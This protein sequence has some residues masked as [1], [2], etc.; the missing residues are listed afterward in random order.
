M[1]EPT[2]LAMP[3]AT[4]PTP[5]PPPPPPPAPKKKNTTRNIL[6]GCGIALVLFICCVA[7][8]VVVYIERDNIPGLDKLFAS[9][10]GGTQN[11]DLIAFT[12]YRNGGEGDI[13]VIHADG[14]GE[15]QITDDPA[16]D[17]D[18]EWSPDGKKL[19]FASNRDGDNEIYI[20]NADGPAPR[21]S[22]SNPATMPPRP[23]RPMAP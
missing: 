23:S 1:D 19:A 14:T 9:S 15:V 18:A 16:N 22:L 10:A 5:V 20:M 8:V 12:S 4:P 13:F 21:A 7:V 17:T 11:G 6:I 2:L 3:S